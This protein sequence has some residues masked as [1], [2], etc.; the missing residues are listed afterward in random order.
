MLLP[1]S[2]RMWG[3]LRRIM[4]T[5]NAENTA[6]SATYEPRIADVLVVKAM[7]ARAL[8]LPAEIIDRITDLA[9]YWPHT[10]TEWSRQDGRI[11]P[12]R[13]VEGSRDENVF[14]V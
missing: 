7:L 12:L 4:S 14:L 10:T 2:Y 13:V 3:L 8:P 1:S 11:A 6:D 9:E 5:A